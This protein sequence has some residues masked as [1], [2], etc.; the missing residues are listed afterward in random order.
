MRLAGA[1][2]LND[3]ADI[4]LGH[5]DD[6]QLHRLEEL[7]VLLLEYDLGAGYLEFITLAA[8]CL[9]EDRE[10]KLSP[11]RNLEAAESSAAG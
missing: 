4:L 7:T 1:E 2:L 11:A 9:D 3:G 10:V 8:H 5:F 6:E